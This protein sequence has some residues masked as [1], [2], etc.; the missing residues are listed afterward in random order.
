MNG[1]D[2]SG[3]AQHSAD[4]YNNNDIP[5]Y[6]EERWI[7]LTN[8][9][10]ALLS[11]VPFRDVTNEINSALEREKEQYSNI[12]WLPFTSRAIVFYSLV[13]HEA[14]WDI[15]NEKPWTDTICT[16]YPGSGK[17][18][19]VYEGHYYTLESLGNYTYGVLGR[20]F[21]FSLKTLFDGSF[22]AAHFPKVGTFDYENEMSDR[23]FIAAGYYS[24]P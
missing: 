16:K 14:P 7:E 21:G 19:V 10:N 17:A 4:D 11:G 22:V 3:F 23:L 1:S 13:N 12:K 15:K 20:E 9:Y 5:D 24:G 2:N 18:V 6:L 8:R